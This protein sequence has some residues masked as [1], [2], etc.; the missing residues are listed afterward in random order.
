MHTPSRHCQGQV[1]IFSLV[2]VVVLTFL[3]LGLVQLASGSRNL[4]DIN[5]RKAQAAW[6]VR[7][8]TEYAKWQLLS[9][10]VGSFRVVD[11]H[12]NAERVA[13]VDGSRLS[14]QVLTGDGRHFVT[15]EPGDQVVVE[16]RSVD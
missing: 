15:A 4:E 5:Y 7:G 9:E 10:D 2:T 1:L 11:V 8:A 3:G 6:R 14:E 12:I 13:R 16:R